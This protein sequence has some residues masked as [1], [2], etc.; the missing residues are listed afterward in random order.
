MYKRFH[1]LCCCA[2]RSGRNRR[3]LHCSTT[4]TAY[5]YKHITLGVMSSHSLRSLPPI[6]CFAI[7]TNAANLLLKAYG[8]ILVL[9]IYYNSIFCWA[10][11]GNKDMFPPLLFSILYRSLVS[12]VKI[13]IFYHFEEYFIP[14]LH[15]WQVL[16]VGIWQC[17]H[18][19]IWHFI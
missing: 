19:F 8:A 18:C 5:S 3:M 10:T 17:W 14:L 16:L 7:Y 13:C 4:T 1:C 15:W 12:L 6:H 2:Q 11:T 9:C